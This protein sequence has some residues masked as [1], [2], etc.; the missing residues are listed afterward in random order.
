MKTPVTKLQEYQIGKKE[1]K[2]MQEKK[3]DCLFRN[4]VLLEPRGLNA[5]SESLYGVE[6]INP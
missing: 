1:L 2:K 3:W 4:D 5:N 6:K